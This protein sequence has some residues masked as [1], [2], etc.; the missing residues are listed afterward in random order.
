MNDS[1]SRRASTKLVTAATKAAVLQTTPQFAK[2]FASTV[3]KV[4]KSDIKTTRDTS[5][6]EVVK[7]KDAKKTIIPE[8]NKKK[9]VNNRKP[10]DI[11]SSSKR[12]LSPEKV[13]N[14]RN[15]F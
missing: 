7:V 10:T 9:V 5:Q 11:G 4:N 6:K 2:K 12:K 8:E 1:R 3:E 15:V 13:T 14:K